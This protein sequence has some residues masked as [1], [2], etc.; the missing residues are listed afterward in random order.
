MRP[1]IKKAAWSLGA[2]SLLMICYPFTGPAEAGW[3]GDAPQC[4][5]VFKASSARPMAA[6]SLQVHH[7]AHAN[8]TF[9]FSLARDGASRMTLKAGELDVEKT[10][11][12]DGRS[13]IALTAGGDRLV[14]AVGLG[15]LDVQRNNRDLHI[16][17]GQATDDDWL[18][19][20]TLL[21]GSRAL[22]LFRTLAFNLDPATLQTPAAASVMSSDA[23]LGYLDGDVAAVDRLNRQFRSA[24]Q[25]RVRPVLFRASGGNDCWNRYEADVVEAADEYDNCRHTFNWYDPRQAGCVFVWTLQAESAW[26]QFLACSAIP[27]KLQ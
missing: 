4:T 15:A 10:V 24:R 1:A 23:I 17:V 18:R 2:C 22:R 11:Y 7:D 25:V 27:L 20:K 26:F 12:H 14:V 6:P 13:Q 8:A 3:T 19:V 9:F 21:A 16:E 5:A